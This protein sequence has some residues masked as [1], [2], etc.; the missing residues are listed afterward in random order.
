MIETDFRE[1]LVQSIENSPSKKIFSR[2]LV[3]CELLG[4]KNS[5]VKKVVNV[6]GKDVVYTQK[7]DGSTFMINRFTEG[8]V[9]KLET[10]GK[11]TE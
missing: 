7:E 11:E 8:V 1:T 3:D 4:I 9:W 10:N 2:I 5:V 6:E